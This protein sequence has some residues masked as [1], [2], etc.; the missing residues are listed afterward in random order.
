[1]APIVAE[2]AAKGTDPQVTERSPNA[3]FRKL[4]S[5]FSWELKR[6]EGAEP[7]RTADLRGVKSLRAI[8]NLKRLFSFFAEF[9][10]CLK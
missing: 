10:G 6:S 3:D 7:Q 1:M 9:S 2:G 5:L 4:T 8:V